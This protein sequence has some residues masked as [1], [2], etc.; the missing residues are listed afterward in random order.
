MFI[1][2]EDTQDSGYNVELEELKL[3][4]DAEELATMGVELAES[5]S[6]LQLGFAR[7]EAKAI[8]EHAGEGVLSES[9]E[10]LL[11]EGV[12]EFFKSAADFVKKYWA[13]FISYIK[14]AIERIK[15]FLT[16]QAKFIRENREALA[17]LSDADLKDVKFS[18]TNVIAD[19][20][21]LKNVMQ[22]ADAYSSDQIQKIETGNAAKT[23]PET[24]QK[25]AI[26]A[27]KI[28]G[29]AAKAD[30]LSAAIKEAINGVKTKDATLTTGDVKTAMEIVTQAESVQ[31]V[32]ATTQTAANNLIKI[33]EARA[34]MGMSTN[35]KGEDKVKNEEVVKTLNNVKSLSPRIGSLFSASVSAAASAASGAKSVL[36]KALAAKAGAPKAKK[37]DSMEGILARFM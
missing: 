31:K 30:S 33:A 4:G 10:M 20:G 24:F 17:K 37:E 35:S 6:M 8:R 21:I 5:Y 3:A 18:R 12:K 23:K 28:T 29:D 26:K 15:N 14:S 27:M 9:T 25:D 1:L 32:L 2:T 13:K 36:S 34:K 19:S 7:L 11:S 16:G 22:G